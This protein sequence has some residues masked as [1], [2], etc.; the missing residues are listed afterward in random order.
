MNFTDTIFAGRNNSIILQL[1]LNNELLTTKYPN[2]I[3]TRWVFTIESSPEQIFDSSL[4][5]ECFSW[6][7]NNSFI[8]IKIGTLFSSAS[9]YKRTRLIMYAAEWP[10]GI[11]WLSPC[12]ID[13]LSVRVCA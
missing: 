8:E 9:G 6:D 2:I 13:T 12:T 7:L 5:P 4:N 1:S 11:V 3:P 10:N